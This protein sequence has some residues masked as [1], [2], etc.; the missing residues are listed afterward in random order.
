MRQNLTPE[1]EKNLGPAST[2]DLVSGFICAAK[3]KPG[4]INQ[5]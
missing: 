5:A 4:A 2:S 1:N 3:E